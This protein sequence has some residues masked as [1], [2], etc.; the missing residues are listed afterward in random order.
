MHKESRNIVRLIARGQTN[1]FGNQ[2]YDYANKLL[3]AGL[4]PQA[5]FFMGLYQSSETVIGIIFDLIGGVFADTRNRK[6]I[7]V[8][9]DL[10]AAAATFLVFLF[11]SKT[12]AWLFVCINIIL[13]LLYSFNSPT[14]KAIVKDLLTKD[15]IYR[16]NSF[17]KSISEF[18]VLFYHTKHLNSLC[19]QTIRVNKRCLQLE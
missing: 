16:Y 18:T 7:L 17:S 10:I 12:N 9:T 14:Y 5:N 15:N 6:L 4:G 11:F 3:I 2:V 1:K 19:Y 8:T 13:A